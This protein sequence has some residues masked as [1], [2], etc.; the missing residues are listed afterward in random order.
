M[1]KEAKQFILG[2][3]LICLGLATVWEPMQLLKNDIWIHTFWNWWSLIAGINLVGIG[4]KNIE[5]SF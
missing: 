3:I 2:F 4:V 1:E 5:D